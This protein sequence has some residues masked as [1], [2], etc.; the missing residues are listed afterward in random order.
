MTRMVLLLLALLPGCASTPWY[1]HYGLPSQQAAERPAARPQ[2]ARA[3]RSGD[4]DHAEQ[5]ARALRRMGVPGLRTLADAAAEG[6]MVAVFTLGSMGPAAAPAV[7]AL[8]RG[9]ARAKDKSSRRGF[10]DTLGR[11]GRPAVAA[12][13]L[14]RRLLSGD[15]SRSVRQH[16]ALA[17][18]AVEAVDEASLEALRQA[19]RDRSHRV[20]KAARRALQRLQL[21]AAQRPAPLRAKAPLVAVLTLEDAA[22]VLDAS[23]LA[24]L[25]TY[26]ETRLTAVGLY[27]VLPAAQVREGLARKRRESYRRCYDVRCQ[28][29]LGRALAAR[30]VLVTKLLRLGGR[31]T[32]TSRLYDLKSEAAER[33]A[34]V[35][36]TCSAVALKAALDQLVQRLGASTPS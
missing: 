9:L 2:L 30:K 20:R 16:A 31:C 21:L 23:A 10:V 29:E 1:R 15:E 36:A 32:L 35:D 27:R 18:A 8:L 12:A 11:I 17:M 4:L 34:T 3:L 26:L 5:A 14:L 25:S 7:G 6:R 19:G 28:I 22:K 24:Q 33:A 13:K